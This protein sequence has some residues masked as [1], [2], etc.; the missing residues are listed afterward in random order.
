M[1]PTAEITS[2]QRPVFSATD[3]KAKNGHE[4]THKA[5]LLSIATILFWFFFSFIL[6]PVFPQFLWNL[7]FIFWAPIRIFLWCYCRQLI[8][9]I[10]LEKWK[11]ERAIW[12]K[13]FWWKVF[14]H[15]NLKLFNFVLDSVLTS[16]FINCELISLSFSR[17]SFYANNEIQGKINEWDDSL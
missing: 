1:S 5:R 16:Y 6:L 10:A 9:S 15:W 3:E 14:V 13:I 2:R 17:W 7:R 12:L 8:S 4:L 11:K